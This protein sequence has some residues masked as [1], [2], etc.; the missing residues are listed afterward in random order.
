MSIKKRHI[1]DNDLEGIIIIVIFLSKYQLL[2]FL[3][4]YTDVN[5]FNLA[6]SLIVLMIGQS[7]S[8]GIISFCSIGMAT[9]FIIYRYYY[10]IQYYFYANAGLSK[11]KLILQ[12]AAVNVILSALVLL[13]IR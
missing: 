2:L 12:V 13:F 5:K 1:H 4:Y 8:A 3:K 10:N 9:S 6:I 7:L 11:I